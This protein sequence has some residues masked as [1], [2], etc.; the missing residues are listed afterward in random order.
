MEEAENR[1]AENALEKLLVTGAREVRLLNRFS[2][3][4]IEQDEPGRGC[5]TFSRLHPQSPPTKIDALGYP[6]P[7]K[8]YEYPASEVR[9]LDWLLRKE[10]HNRT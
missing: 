8:I 9:L 6:K 7:R 10:N 3:T 5:A 4:Q 2:H 1:R